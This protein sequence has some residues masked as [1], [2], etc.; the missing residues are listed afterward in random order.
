MTA[1]INLINLLPVNPL[2]G[3][4]VLKALAYSERFKL[5][6]VA[7]LVISVGTAVLGAS[8]GLWLLVFM[9]FIGVFDLVETFGA[10]KHL[11]HVLECFLTIGSFGFALALTLILLLGAGDWWWFWVVCLSVA[12]LL[13]WF[14]A[15]WQLKPRSGDKGGQAL[16]ASVGLL[17]YNITQFRFAWYELRRFPK[18]NINPLADYAILPMRGKVGYA[19][20]FAV[21]VAL[22]AALIVWLG[23]VPG[24]EFGRELVE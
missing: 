21:L 4:R 13:L 12:N 19:I 17:G 24:A 23:S 5:S 22:H 2:D 6:L 18:L 16:Y 10:R 15:Y 20:G 11:T 1:V 14:G 7:T 9:A 8:F 3:G